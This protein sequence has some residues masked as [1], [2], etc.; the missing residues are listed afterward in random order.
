MTVVAEFPCLDSLPLEKAMCWVSVGPDL[1]ESIPDGEFVLFR[2][3]P[4]ESG[5]QKT[6]TFFHWVLETGAGN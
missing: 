3:E 5:V 4:E 1:G 2:D 6:L